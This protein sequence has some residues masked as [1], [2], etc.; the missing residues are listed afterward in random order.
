[1]SERFHVKRG[2]KQG[3]ALSPLL[4]NY[5]LEYVIRRVQANKEGLKLNGTHQLLVYADDV[6]TLGGSIHTI[7]KNTEVL[8]IASKET[9]LDVN[10]EKTKYVVM[11]RDQNAGQN[12]N[13]KTSNKSFETLE[14]FK[15]WGET[16]TN[17]EESKSRL[18]SGNPRYHSVQNILSSGMLSKNVKVKI[19][20]IIILPV[21]LY[22]CETW[23][24][25][26]REEC[27]LRVFKNRMLRRIFGPK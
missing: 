23:S 13:I 1:L 27:R 12:S 2:L 3:D 7:R 25:I 20:R 19:Y 6:N 16:S 5:G 15:H 10:A 22:G 8:V 26:L 21:V 18:M 17:N 4:F 9:A 11:S 24:L 14:Q